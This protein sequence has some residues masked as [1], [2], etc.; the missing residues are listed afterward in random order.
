MLQCA[1]N[2]TERDEPRKWLNRPSDRALHF[3]ANLARSY[4]QMRARRRSA[5]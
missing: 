4:A 1:T 2:Q 5:A 3:E